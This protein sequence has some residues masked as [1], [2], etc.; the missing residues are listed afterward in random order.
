[1]RRK[2]AFPSAGPALLTLVLAVAALVPGVA[3]AQW[4][5]RDAQGQINVSDRPP[6][7][8]VPVKDILSRPNDNARRA[9]APAS[10]ASGTLAVPPRPAP[11]RE[12]EARKR[13]ADA[14]KDAKTKAEEQRLAAQRAENCQRAR[15]HLAGLES[16]QRIA[17]L[18][19]KGEREVLDDRGRAEEM[20]QAREVIAAD[21][22]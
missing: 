7:S 10:A 5:W 11:D 22:R 13:A 4:K 3:Q 9:A 21:C 8:D 17:R 16:G 18:N 2:P 12:L 1:M 20:R 19:D 15:N 6:P 14:E